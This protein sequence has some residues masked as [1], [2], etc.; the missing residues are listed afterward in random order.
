MAEVKKHPLRRWRESHDQT[1]LI[2]DLAKRVGVH[3]NYLGA[4]ELGKRSPSWRLARK[5]QKVTGIAAAD[6]L[7]DDVT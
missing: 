6:L 1:V 4:I 2:R 5:L 3:E 7:P